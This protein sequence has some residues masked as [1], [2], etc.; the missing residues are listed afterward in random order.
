MSELSGFA[1]AIARYKKPIAGSLGAGALI[2]IIAI[3]CIWPSAVAWSLVAVAAMIVAGGWIAIGS[4]RGT[5]RELVRLREIG[6][7]QHRDASRWEYRLSQKIQK[8]SEGGKTNQ[9]AARPTTPRLD[10]PQAAVTAARAQAS[11][12]ASHAKSAWW[13]DA[14]G[15]EELARSSIFNAVFYG[16]AAGARF[17]RAEDAASHYI[18]IG[19]GKG[20]PFHELIPVS[21]IPEEIRIQVAEMGS[22]PLLAFFEKINGDVE[23]GPGLCVSACARITGADLGWEALDAYLRLIR[24]QPQTPIAARP[25]APLAEVTYE[26]V[27]DLQYLHTKEL[28]AEKPLRRPR[29]VKSWDS[30]REEAWKAEVDSLWNVAVPTPE[31]LVS[32]ILPVYN[33]RDLL[34][35]AVGSVLAQTYGE[36]E[37][38]IVDDG[39]DDGSWEFAHRLSTEHRRI[40][41]IRNPGKGVSSARNAGIRDSRGTY[42]AF[43]DSDN[44]WRPDHLRYALGGLLT[45]Q[46]EWGYAASCVHHGDGRCGYRGMEGALAELL[47]LNHIDMNVLVLRASL[48][49]E[50]GGFDE[51]LRRWVDH[52]LAIRL[53]KHVD[54][55]Y[56]P[57]IGCDYEHSMERGDRITVKESSHWQWRVLGRGLV[58]WTEV[59]AVERVE[60]LKSVVIPTYDDWEMTARAVHS[61]T[62]NMRG[63]QYEIIVVDNGCS[64]PISLA[65]SQQVSGVP[66]VR[67]VRLPKNYNFAIGCN[68]GFKA[69]RGS[70]VL[71]LNNDTACRQ[72]EL[73]HL[74]SVLDRPEVLGVQP[75]LLFADDTIQTSGTVWVAENGLPVH[76]LTGQPREDA[77]C[78]RELNFPAL[79][80]AALLVRADDFGRLEGFDPFFVNGMEDVDFCLRLA[81]S[82]KGNFAVDADVVVTHFESQTPGRGRR[83]S[84]NRE[85]FVER[86]RDRMPAPSLGLYEAASLTVAGVA[87]DNSESAV[88][89]PRPLIV[90]APNRARRWGIKIAANAGQRG[91][92]WG[93]THFAESLATALRVRGEE[94]VLYR[95]EARNAASTC[96]DDVTL[97]IRGLDRVRPVPGRTSLLWVIS[98]PDDVTAKEALAFDGVFSASPTWSAEYAAMIGRDVGVLLQ[99][100][101]TS[102]FC[103]SREKLSRAPECDIVF[104]GSNLSKRKRMGVELAIEA[105]VDLRVYGPGWRGKIPARYIYDEYVS[106]DELCSV[107]QTA[108]FV[109]ADHWGDMLSHGFLQ[110][111]VFDALASGTMVLCEPIAGIPAELSPYIATYETAS[112]IRSAVEGV[113]GTRAFMQ[114][115]SERVRSVHSFDARAEALIQFVDSRVGPNSGVKRGEVHCE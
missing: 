63:Q 82:R 115:V 107:Y 38:I 46:A 64:L 47:Y 35:L 99:A 49:A 2:A 76:F 18:R 88:L 71:F 5:Q 85:I 55:V 66:G 30:A 61:V 73:T 102:R 23:I 83:V 21:Y 80:A 15:A 81:E 6:K 92:G 62:D 111:R 14:P 20:L 44:T 31:P 40:R 53:A 100:T 34:A 84:E 75:L 104:V 39:S 106:N 86:W 67:I 79:S 113:Q 101:D 54:P 70:A 51:S 60:G 4:V 112:D 32:V 109:L 19:V 57:Y 10:L 1:R 24:Q 28:E 41:C 59:N 16:H 108:K 48:L 9:S 68:V 90:R 11:G 27:R 29:E 103:A 13:K 22:K 17:G 87:S 110:N 56:F 42:L 74:W 36:W 89:G 26:A 105:G 93:D 91:D 72:G 50:V 77:E 58:D 3:A 25:G 95:H 65:L 52:D 37:L 78:V 98:H 69:S 12:G 8:L 94:V 43:I 114:S 33:R 96:L 97:V 7:V 45:S